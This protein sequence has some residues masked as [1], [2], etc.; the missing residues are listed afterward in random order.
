MSTQEQQEPAN[1]Q[2]TGRNEDGTFK[3]GISG[4]PSGRPKNTLKDYIRQKFMNMTDEQK[5]E[6]LKTISPDVQWRM[7]EGNPH[8]TEDITSGGE[9]V[10]PIYGTFQ[11]HD[12][13]KKD[14]QPEQ[15]NPGS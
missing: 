11:R 6:F 3:P 15:T 2:D 7:G 1:R 8:N 12:S 10:I 9:K 13:D 5:E 14:I 4:N